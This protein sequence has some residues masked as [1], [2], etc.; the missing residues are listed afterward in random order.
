ML[1]VLDR[2]YFSRMHWF[3]FLLLR[4]VYHGQGPR[5]SKKKVVDRELHIS[6]QI[7]L[8]SM[9]H[10][11]PPSSIIAIMADN[12]EGNVHSRMAPSSHLDIEANTAAEYHVTSRAAT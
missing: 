9:R 10:H 7:N 4:L 2:I 5:C 11:L 1:E 3:V 6:P 8:P 12:S